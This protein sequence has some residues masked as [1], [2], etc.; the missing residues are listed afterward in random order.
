MLAT[1]RTFQKVAIG[2]QVKTLDHSVYYYL[3]LLEIL[4]GDEIFKNVEYFRDCRKTL[5][6][7]FPDT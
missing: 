6:Q 4:H 3:L 1:I 2:K 5:N 7:V